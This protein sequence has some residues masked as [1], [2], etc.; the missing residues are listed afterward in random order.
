MRRTSIRSGHVSRRYPPRLVRSALR[1][2]VRSQV[3]R[4]APV[5]LLSRC[6]MGD[7]GLQHDAGNGSARERR[8]GAPRG[9]AHR[10]DRPCFWLDPAP[11]GRASSPRRGSRVTLVNAPS[12][13][14]RHRRRQRAAA[15]RLWCERARATFDVPLACSCRAPLLHL[16]EAGLHP[17]ESRQDRSR[18][19]DVQPPMIASRSGCSSY[20]GAR[21]P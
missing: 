15:G 20:I 17:D 16:W 7:A 11:S 14:G 10:H 18:F 19:A 12:A 1:M 5:T 4:R 8:A 2:S 6:R 9:G 13:W 3:G 21:R